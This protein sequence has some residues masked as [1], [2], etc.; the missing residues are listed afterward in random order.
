M[1]QGIPPAFLERM[2]SLLG[3]EFADFLE[4]YNQ[5][6]ASGLRVNTLKL[7]PAEFVQLSSLELSPVAWCP[8]AFHLPE[9]AQP[10]KHPQHAAG[11]YYL[12]DPSAMLAAETL[13]PVP[14]ERV[15]DLAAAPGGKA[16]HLAALLQGQGSLVANEIHPRRV[17]ELAENLE[18][19]GAAN[20]T[21]TNETPERLAEAFGAI[22]DKV[23]LDAPCSGEGMFRKSEPARQAWSP[24]LVES[25]AR[26][27]ALLLDQARGTGAAGRQPAV[28]HLHVLG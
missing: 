12:Q 25:C 27:Q 13:R 16:T 4:C 5:P 22:F 8:A 6:P 24:G 21:I 2:H 10:G 11:L 20:V 7:T 9:N 26:R 3:D 19:W 28:H 18:R 17:W 14:G 23:L 15:L 1:I